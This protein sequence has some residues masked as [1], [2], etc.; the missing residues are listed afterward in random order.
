MLGVSA[1]ALSRMTASARMAALA[2]VAF[3]PAFA[4]D[5]VAQGSVATDRAA[6]EA[7]YDATGGASWTNSTNWKTSAPLGEWHGVTTGSAGRVTGLSLNANGL[8]GP[9]PGELGSL[10][11]LGRLDLH[12]NALTGPIPGALRSLASLWRLSVSGNELTGPIP[13]WLGS[14][15][16]LRELYL[17]DNALTGAVPSALGSLANLG[18]LYLGG[19]PLTGSIPAALGSLTSLKALSIGGTDLTGPI[20]A[21]LGSLVELTSLYLGDNALTGPIP[22]DLGSLVKLRSLHLH[23]NALTGPVPAWLGNL[24]GLDRL[25]MGGND[26]TGPIPADLGS[27]VNLEELSLDENDLTGPIPAALGNLASLERL[28]LQDNGLTGRIPGELGS[29]SNLEYLHLSGNPLTGSL[30]QELT[31]LSR[32]RLLAIDGTGACAPADARFQAWLATISFFGRT[33]NR[34]PQP[35]GAIPAQTLTESGPAGSVPVAA[36]FSDPDGDALMYA[37]A[38]SHL[39]TVFS[40]VSGDTVRLVPGTA[41]TATVTVTARDRDGLRATQT[42]AVTVDASA[43]PQSEREVLEVL[44]DATNGAS[45]TNSTNWKTSAPLGEWFGVTTDADGVAGLDLGYNGLAGPIPPA[46]GNLVNLESLGLYGNDL[47]GPIPDELGNLVNLDELVL[48]FNDLTGPIPAS[49]G[50]LA[51]LRTLWVSFNDLTGPIPAELASLANLTTVLLRGNRLTGPIPAWWGNLAGLVELYL[52]QNDFS[53]PIPRELGGLVNLSLLDLS[54]NRL[55]GPIPSELGSLVNLSALD[56]NSNALTGPI[57]GGLGSLANLEFLDLSDN[58]GLSGRLPAGLRPG[59]LEYLDIFFTQTCAP[60]ASRDWLETI[61][62]F[63]G[64]LCE[65]GTDATIDV[66]VVYT[67]GAREAAG[68]SAGIEAVIDLMIAETNQAYVASGVGHRV[69]LVERSEV[70]YTATFLL[71]DL[72]RLQDPSDGHLDELHPLRDRVGAD[73]VHLIVGGGQS[74]GFCGIAAIGGA[75]GVTRQHCGGRTFAH[76]LGHNMGLQ[77]DRY[78]LL[79]ARGGVRSHPAYGYVNQPGLAA[80]APSS[81]RWRTVMSYADQCHDAGIYCSE[82]L[83]FSNPRQRYNGDPL[84]VPFGGSGLG[85][86]GPSDASAVLA[87][88]GPAVAL[89]RSRPAGANQPPVAVGTLPDRELTLDGTLDVDVSPTFVDPDGDALRYRVSSSAP[90]VVTVRAAGARVTLTAVG[91]GATTVRVTATDPGGLSVSQSFAATVTPPPNRPPEPVGTLA[92]VTIGV[93]EAAVTVDVSTAFRDPDGDAL[94]YAASSSAP[95]IA[96]VVVSGSAV[97]VTP[98]AEGTTTVTVTATDTGGSNTPATQTFAVTVSPPANRPPEPLGTLSPVTI[99]VGEATISVDVSTAFRDPDGD[100]LTYAA[101]SSAP[102]VAA[103]MVREHGD[104]DGSGGGDG[105]G[106]GDRDRCRRLEHAGGPEVRRDGEQPSARTGAR[107]GVGGHWCRRGVGV[108]RVVG[109]VP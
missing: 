37:A 15:V 85:P 97:I 42:M 29:L 17:R 23:D 77:H 89:W 108:G 43:D 28:R 96:S 57:P 19:N 33:C 98:V 1:V 31:R 59:R 52:D 67:P 103:V 64:R 21:D 5:A 91:T 88:T 55:T 27:L 72:F 13:A 75:F 49:L 61:D 99:G 50:N 105:G 12:R 8:T 20:P 44:Y 34:A 39:A 41:G 18:W 66:A 65:A 84:G 74:G 47:I 58:W 3:W 90:D 7:L 22:A 80:G 86:T 45:W 107:A 101:S 40:F 82:L 104:G 51:R 60:V 92:P 54:S 76:E 71:V 4:V 6:L 11:N 46:L 25:Y 9:I 100:A 81:S 69:A 102:A 36:Y 35:V 78:Q 53:G 79:R 30:P 16:N 87:A 106:H 83:R 10:A 32:L 94:T 93:N 73:L 68:G 2:A 63:N 38:S 24:D 14:L 56:L 48:S 109:G 26:L 62:Y 70:R 95:G